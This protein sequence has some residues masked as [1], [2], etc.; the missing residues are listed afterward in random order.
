MTEPN[1][2]AQEQGLNF[3]SVVEAIIKR[4]CIID[5]G[6]IQK[7]VA[8]GVVEVA[9]A[10]AKTEEDMLCMTCVLANTASTAL[11]IDIIPHVGDRVLVVYP[12][13][14]N[15]KMFN[16]TDS[17]DDNA[18]LTIDFEAQGY[19][20]M[21]GIAIL[22][23]QCKTSAHKNVITFEDGK[24]NIKLGYSADEDKNFLN[25][26]TTAD[27]DVTLSNDKCFVTIDKDGAFTFNNEKAS[28]C[29]DTDGYLDYENTDDNNTKLRF[30][31]SGMTMQDK[32]GCKIV[33]SSSGMTIQDNNGCKI[34]S[35]STD[36][37]ING[38][39]KVL[40]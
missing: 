24:V 16:V 5:Y 35:S 15:D 21:S 27:G 23:N 28:A 25:I 32:N 4:S 26:S 8:K 11:T 6:I 34:V 1:F 31:S 36:I 3:N 29:I 37:Q 38:K 39:L 2:I 18:K 9:V 14:Y 20:L 22:I 19:N 10:V 13:L 12:R 7:V 17:E 30:T 40:K 33:S